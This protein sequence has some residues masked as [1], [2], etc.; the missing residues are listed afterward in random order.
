MVSE[1]WSRLASVLGTNLHGQ[2]LNHTAAGC[3]IEE[4]ENPFEFGKDTN[5]DLIRKHASNTLQRSQVLD[6]VVKAIYLSTN[7]ISMQ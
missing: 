3:V 1:Y 5:K 6:C 2:L 4:L 7:G